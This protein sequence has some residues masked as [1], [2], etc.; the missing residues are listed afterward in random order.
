[1]TPYD[2]TPIWDDEDYWAMYRSVVEHPTERTPRLILADWLDERGYPVE[3]LKHRLDAL[4]KKEIAS[5]DHRGYVSIQ[6][7]KFS[8]AAFWNEVAKFHQAGS[9]NVLIIQW[10]AKAREQYANVGGP[11]Y[12]KADPRL[13]TEVTD[14][15]RLL[16]IPDL[17]GLYIEAPASRFWANRL[18]ND[19]PN[20]Q[21]LRWCLSDKSS[22]LPFSHL[23][24]LEDLDFMF[25]GA[26]SWVFAETC[27]PLKHLYIVDGQP[28]EQEAKTIAGWS[29]ESFEIVLGSYRDSL[30]RDDFPP[31]LPTA[32]YLGL[33]CYA[34]QYE[35]REP[36]LGLADL[37]YLERLD[38]RMSAPPEFRFPPNLRSL[39]ITEDEAPGSPWSTSLPTGLTD[40]SLRVRSENAAIFDALEPLD[41]LR[42]FVRG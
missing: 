11:L 36:F 2:M 38:L 16:A 9:Q 41:Q 32:K 5:V 21:A 42:R 25:M 31:L 4:A 27:P 20:L 26:G 34:F 35:S 33:F 8:S 10:Q 30:R 15:Q 24:K 19:C 14:Y 1:M 17:F 7:S 22:Y 37:K 12:V 13:L 23:P 40:L 18:A 3:A 29:L 6:H 39:G 28:T